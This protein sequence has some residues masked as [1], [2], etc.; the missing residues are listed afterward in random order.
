MSKKKT[1][2]KVETKIDSK[3]M[4]GLPTKYQNWIFLGLLI[5]LITIINK[6][7]AIDGLAP[8]G[9]DVVAGIGKTNYIN[10]FAKESGEFPLWNPAIFAGMPNYIDVKPAELAFSVD[11]LL[12]WFNNILGKVYIYYLFAAFGMYFFLRYLKMPPLVAFIG[13]L[14]FVLLPHYKG[15][16]VEGHF[17]KF[18]ALMYLP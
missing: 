3:E 14:M 5:L 18:R 17:R 1:T 12:I 6:P 15:L 13:A 4:F 10:E 16:W 11:N 8:Q 2:P 7:T 9:T